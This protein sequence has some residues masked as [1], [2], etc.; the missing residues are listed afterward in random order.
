LRRKLSGLNIAVKGRGTGGGAN[1]IGVMMKA[2]TQSDV[3]STTKAII[4]ARLGRWSAY[5]RRELDNG[6]G[7]PKKSA[8]AKRSVSSE[9]IW[10]PADEAECWETGQAIQQL[11]HL[12]QMVI[13]AKWLKN[14]LMKNRYAA[15]RVSQSQFSRI[16]LA[17][18]DN[19]AVAL[20]NAN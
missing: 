13:R 5:E 15:L 19:L 9:H 2:R 10:T 18:I 16:Y 12:E 8:F 4:E 20:R 17:A 7:Y 6:N 1:S 14:G 11:D 3:D